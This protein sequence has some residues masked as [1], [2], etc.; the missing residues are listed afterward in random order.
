MEVGG[1]GGSYSMIT[2]ENLTVDEEDPSGVEYSEIGNHNI[3]L[4]THSSAPLYSQVVKVSNKAAD[5]EA[6]CQGTNNQLGMF[7][8]GM[9]LE[10]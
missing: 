1:P 2:L 9:F 3:I 7:I 4:T 6:K 10:T 8:P 5:G